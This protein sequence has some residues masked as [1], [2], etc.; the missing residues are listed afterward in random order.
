VC[1][2]EPLDLVHLQ[3][4]VPLATQIGRGRRQT[5]PGEQRVDR[6][7]LSMRR[8]VQHTHVSD[9]S[10]QG[11]L[12][13]GVAHER[14]RSESAGDRSGF[15]VRE[16]QPRQAG[17][18]AVGQRQRPRSGLARAT[19]VGKDAGARQHERRVFV[20]DRLLSVA[21]RGKGDIVQGTVRD[22]GQRP[23]AKGQQQLGRRDQRRV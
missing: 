2:I 14:A 10:S 9:S 11:T 12:G 23:D 16:A 19:Y 6:I 17:D 8:Y 5:D 15:I 3:R 4:S 20:G 18:V 22:D 13:R 7:E 1:E 21:Q